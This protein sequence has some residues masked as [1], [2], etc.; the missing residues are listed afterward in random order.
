MHAKDN[1]LDNPLAIA[2]LN[3]R[4]DMRLL[5]LNRGVTWLHKTGQHWTMNCSCRLP[6]ADREQ[7][8]ELVSRGADVKAVIE[9]GRGAVLLACLVGDP[10][11]MKLLLDHGAPVDAKD[12]YELTP[13]MAAAR[14]GRI[15]MVNVLLEQGADPN[16]RDK[17][18]NTSLSLALTYGH[19]EVKALLEEQAGAPAAMGSEMKRRP[20]SDCGVVTTGVAWE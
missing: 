10:G 7:V 4:E 19:K 15:E 16:A 9:S 12:K 5:L 20:H 17:Q 13:L 6:T 1:D 14:W 11:I 2:I 3:G 8:K 18:G